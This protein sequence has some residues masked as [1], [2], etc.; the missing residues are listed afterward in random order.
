MSEISSDNN[1]L[2]LHDSDKNFLESIIKTSNNLN[3]NDINRNDLTYIYEIIKPS[4]T[5]IYIRS[6][7]NVLSK[8]NEPIYKTTK[9]K[10]LCLLSKYFLQYEKV[11]NYFNKYFI[12]NNID[13]LINEKIFYSKFFKYILHDKKYIT[14]FNFIPQEKHFNFYIECI[15]IVKK[16]IDDIY[17]YVNQSQYNILKPSDFTM[18]INFIELMAEYSLNLSNENKK[19]LFEK[20]ETLIINVINYIYN[21]IL[22]NRDHIKIYKLMNSSTRMSL[23]D[24]SVQITYLEKDTNIYIN[25]LRD[26]FNNTLF[27]KYLVDK[28][29]SFDINNSDD[30]NIFDIAPILGQQWFTDLETSELIKDLSNN[31]LSNNLKNIFSSEKSNIHTLAKLINDSN[32]NIFYN[33]DSIKNLILFYNKLENYGEDTGFY[34]KNTTRDQIVN[35]ITSYI[36]NLNCDE[37]QQNKHLNCNETSWHI[38]STPIINNFDITDIITS[39]D[40]NQ[41]IRHVILLISDLCEILNSI[42]L[43]T[44]FE[45]SSVY[46]AY[47]CCSSLYKMYD[48][49]SLITYVIKNI[50]NNDIVTSKVCELIHCIF[51]NFYKKR[52][53]RDIFELRKSG[54]GLE[55]TSDKLANHIE[56]FVSDFYKDINTLFNNKIYMDYISSH[57]ELYNR[58]E[59]EETIKII[60]FLN[61]D[62]DTVENITNNYIKN[63]DE[64][65]FKY[66]TSCDKYN[67]DIPDEFIDPIYYTPITDPLEL[68]ET[69]TIVDKKII[70]NHL[71]FKPTNPFNGLGLT[72]DELIEYN[73]DKEVKERLQLFK[74]K[75][76]DWKLQHKI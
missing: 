6:L 23:K 42:K 66:S 61:I 54:Y 51:N 37:I 47:K 73:N 69:R 27:V 13:F 28:N 53:F 63:L 2:N 67:I 38:I 8:L 36:K 39:I 29:Q 49:Y 16:N 30:N 26:I 74:N 17:S 32:K 7:Q 68:P 31:V 46:S 19:Y 64:T 34:E 62:G 72:H 18:H 71:F 52:I 48:Y 12:I 57:E 25:W 76:S 45:N 56:K 58:T 59:I 50:N 60:G 75:F 15:D 22:T 21:I 5:D 3:C 10:L 41:L 35:I 55:I 40:S 9:F 4:S 44:D 43:S 70:L 14:H 11:T 1:Q 20:I 24:I 33:E 65:I